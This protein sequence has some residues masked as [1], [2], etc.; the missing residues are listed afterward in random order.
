[1]TLWQKLVK[2]STV[3]S[4]KTKWEQRVNKKKMLLTKIEKNLTRLIQVNISLCKRLISDKTCTEQCNMLN[5][6]RTW[7]IIS[8]KSF[9]WGCWSKFEE[10]VSR[11][12]DPFRWLPVSFSSSMVWTASKYYGMVGVSKWWSTM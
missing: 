3:I 5:H 1:M 8:F 4:L 7:V 11:G 12:R 9:Q 10:N 6:P 2:K